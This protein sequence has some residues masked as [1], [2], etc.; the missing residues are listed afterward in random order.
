MILT[1]FLLSDH[2]KMVKAVVVLGSS[3]GVKGTIQFT[4]EGDGKLKFNTCVLGL[5]GRI[6]LII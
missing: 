5:V 2:R 6:L 4:Q 3:E 1:Y